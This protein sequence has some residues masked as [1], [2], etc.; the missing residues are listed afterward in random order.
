MQ[1]KEMFK[2]DIERKINGVVQVEQEKEDVIKQ[3]VKEYVVTSELKKHYTQF[4]NEYSESFSEP[5]DNVGVWITG[6]FGSGKSHFLKMLSYLLEN[7]EVDGKKTTDYFREKFDDELSFMNI[8]KCVEVPTETILFNIDVE[9]SGQKDDTAVLR[10]F[11]KVFYDHLG[12]YGNDLKLAKLEQYISKKGKMDAFKEA[13]ENIN[14]ESWVNTRSDFSFF[15]DDIIDALVETDVMSQTNAEHWFDGSESYDISIAQL[16]DEIK[17]YVDTKPKDFRLLFMIDEVGQYIGTN[18]SMLLNLQSLIEK[19]GSVCRGKVWIVA[20]GQEALDEM[21]KVRTDEFSRIMARFAIRLS[22]TSSSVGEV[23]EK[24]LLTK[25]DEANTVLDNV[26]ENNENVLSNLFTFDT[27]VKDLKGYSSEDEFARVFPFVPYQFIIMQK[28]FNE[29]RKHGHAGKHQSSG[30]RSM[31]N[32]FQESAQRIEEKNELT[33]VPMYAFYDTLHSFLD[34]SVRS[35]MERAEKAAEEGNGLTVEDVDLLKLLYLVRYID[36]IKSNIENLT[37]LMADSINVDMIELR[38]QVIKSLERLQRHNYIGRNGEIY[39]FLTDEEQDIAREINNQSIDAANVISKV[40]T[41]IF[42]DIYTTKKYR[43]TKNGYNYDFDFIKSVDNQNHGNSNGE[44]KLK[45]V[46]EAN[47][48]S[49][50][51]RLIT[52]SKGYEA[53]CKLSEEYSIFSDIENALKIEKYIRQKNVSQLAESTQ[54]II[55]LKQKEARRLIGDAKEHISDAILHGKFY[56]DGD[57]KNISGNNA[58]SVLD[59]ALETLVEHTYD[60]ITDIEESV[61]N[62]A[63]IRTILNGNVG[64]EGMQANQAA[65]DNVYS[66]LET[67]YEQKMPVSMATLQGR[68]QSIPYGWKEI[69]IAAIVARLIQA[70]RVT[71]KHSGQTIQPNDYYLVDYLR[72]K[73]ETG[74]TNI[75]IRETIPARKM[76]EVKDILKDYFDVMDIPADEDGLVSYIVEHFKDEKIHLEELKKQ[77]DSAV[78]PG[79]SEINEALSYVNKVLLAKD[80]NIAL[81]NTICELEDD[82]LD[83]KESME[84]VENFYA[85]QIKLYDN[86]SK[87]R[88]NVITYEKDY[89]YDI[90]V[91]RDAVD[92]ITDIIKITDNFRYNRIS[93]LNECISVIEEEKSKVVA[94]KKEELNDLIDSCMIEVKYKADSS[95]KL[96]DILDSVKHQFDT[97]RDEVNRMSDLVALDAKKNTIVKLKDKIIRDMDEVLN[98]KEVSK[99]DKP[100]TSKK[101]K[102]QVR[103][104]QRTVFFGQANLSSVADVDHYLA[105]IKNRLLS[106]INDNE[107]IKIK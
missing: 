83:S 15:E 18:T 88:I 92:Q 81:V 67:K 78:H 55:N 97:K 22:L 91:V 24:R 36:D 34:T 74:Q 62:D 38:Q 84:D 51:L 59:N 37:I 50:E 28:V 44:M 96:K 9:S 89:L 42:D 41:I 80:D 2:G 75:S 94:T 5:T 43:Y 104:L 106:Y 68:Y 105:N 7:K 32:G 3:E 77:N 100:I 8:Q 1:I 66:Y 31:L 98:Q 103:E 35:V 11:S 47:D 16:V 102:K 54:T 45:F 57:Q 46:T 86:A 87:T 71:V 56:I 85:S 26:Y 6:F 39:Q 93:Q 52:E 49:S 95:V 61:S 4:F 10:V 63:D 17:E 90:P 21:I 72:K 76:K 48:D 40:C 73:S 30:E 20:T 101:R 14:G 13:F 23:I 65:C 19:L 64:M 29:I 58:K 27:E 12:F 53:I 33:L 82:L 60:H 79:A 99:H 69:D 70:Q 25:T 107:E